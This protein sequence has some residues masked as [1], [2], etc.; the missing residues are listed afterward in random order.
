MVLTTRVQ[1]F[2]Q[3]WG[4]SP[5]YF[6]LT[7]INRSFSAIGAFRTGEANLAALDR[8][9]RVTTAEV[10]VELLEALAVQPEHGR[11]FRRDETR[12]N[13]PAVV[14]V[15]HVLWQSAFAARQDIVGRAIEVNGVMREVV[16]VMPAG[17]DV[18]DNRIDVWQ[19]LGV[20]LTPARRGT[21]A[22]T[23]SAATTVAV[24]DKR[25]VHAARL[26]AGA[27]TG[28]DRHRQGIRRCVDGPARSESRRHPLEIW[29]HTPFLSSFS[30]V[31][32]D[33]LAAGII[34]RVPSPGP[35]GQRLT[36][37][38]RFPAS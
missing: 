10:N 4:S 28:I 2:E 36:P 34:D 25:A 3:F 33:T 15:S 20:E 30:A 6:E 21:P 8:P 37:C 18:M 5:E 9:R 13:G 35:D 14:M 11:W 31:K 27:T 23:R 32:L 22:T 38:A 29:A 7:E 12:M 17:F 19:P 24:P 26:Q 16:G 1:G